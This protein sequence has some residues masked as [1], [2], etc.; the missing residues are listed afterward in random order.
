LKSASAAVG[1]SRDHCEVDVCL[2]AVEL[3]LHAA[4]RG[5][6]S[7]EISLRMIAGELLGECL[8]TSRRQRL[9]DHSRLSDRPAEVGVGSAS[10]WYRFGASS[11]ANRRRNQPRSTRL[12][13]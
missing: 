12:C 7:A 2:Q 9:L 11:P 1:V 4:Q 13:A 6:R 5:P 10:V 3:S 8:L